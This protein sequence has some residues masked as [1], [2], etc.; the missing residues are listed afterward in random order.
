MSRAVATVVAYVIV[1][2]AVACW[3]LA[4]GSGSVAA[5]AGYAA[6]VAVALASAR[7]T[8]RVGKVVHDWLPLLALPVLYALVP[9]TVPPPSGGFHDSVV[10]GWD[11][12]IFG[13]D[14][15][16]TLAGAMPWIAL[17]ALLHL[18]YL[19]YYLII[20]LPPLLLYL[21]ADRRAFSSTVIAFSVSM[22][23][24][25]VGFAL[26]PV[27]G[28]RY[29]WPAPA[30]IPNDPMRGI[31]LFLL[32]RGSSRGTAF[33]S[34]HVAIA[35]TMSLAC[36][37]WRPRLGLL[38]SSTT[39]LMAIGAVYGGFHYAA[40]VLAGLAF[41]VAAWLVGRRLDIRTAETA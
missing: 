1:A 9:W 14:A 8:S 41:G 30:G 40:D 16:R 23:A 2:A 31:A 38:V 10:Q 25:F 17:S 7:S 27:E 32:E 33:P 29:A 3:R 15:A 28:P 34:S 13:T 5:L 37:R 12:G 20:Y 18:A 26:F 6:I 19:A 22:V 24:A 39:T 21:S 11:R 35:V 4:S 36:L